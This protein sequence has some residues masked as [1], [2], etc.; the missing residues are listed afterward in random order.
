V[1]LTHWSKA[2]PN[3]GTNNQR[4]KFFFAP[5]HIEKRFKEW[6]P[7]R[8]DEKVNGFFMETVQ[9]TK[10]WLEYNEME[11]LEALAK[12]HP[13]VCNGTRSPKEGIIIKL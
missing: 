6:G 9:K 7:A 8:F 2:N 4:S 10:D 12:V 11:G 13:E 3:V 1:G 5:A